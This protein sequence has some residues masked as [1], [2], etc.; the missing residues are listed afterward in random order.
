MLL[1]NTPIHLP[2]FEG[3]LDLL[4]QLIER[5]ELDI[6]EVSLLQVT[7]Q[8]LAIIDEMGRQGLAD[9]TAFLVVAARLVLIKSRALLPDHRP[10][11]E[12]ADDAAVDLVRQLELYRR[13]KQA[14]QEL[15]RRD[16]EG[17]R[18][19]VRVDPARTV[20]AWYDLEEV[21]LEGLLGAAQQALDALPALPVEEVIARITLTVADQIRH[22][23]EQLQR[24]G[25]VSF[26][27]VLSRSVNRVEV[28][29][30][31][32][33]VLELLKQDRIRVWQEALFASIFI[34]ERMPEEKD[35]VERY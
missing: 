32:L 16:E 5:E 23:E 26:Q 25:R 30:T 15:A 1:A 33:A 35:D 20:P 24:Q 17:L 4:L 3:P 11:D 19:F 34:E 18:S 27:Q 21:T 8:Y 6:T 13:F 9:L 7:D 2:V 29:V 10:A 14:A 28:I 22:I 31:L 12:G